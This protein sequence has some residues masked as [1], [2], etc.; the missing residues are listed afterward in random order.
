[1]PCLIK[2]KTLWSWKMTTSAEYLIYPFYQYICLVGSK[3]KPCVGGRR[4]HQQWGG[5][6]QSKLY[7]SCWQQQ[8]ILTTTIQFRKQLAAKYLQHVV[9]CNLICSYMQ[10]GKITLPSSHPKDLVLCQCK[11]S[12]T[13]HCKPCKC[14][15]ERASS[16]NCIVITF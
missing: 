12:G 14:M 13:W 2:S 11:L 4:Q 15:K 9:L 10:E 5:Q 16:M 1:M 6:R 3:V 7:H 8:L